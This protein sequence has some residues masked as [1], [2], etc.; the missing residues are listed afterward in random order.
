MRSSSSDDNRWYQPRPCSPTTASA[1]ARAAVE[2]YLAGATGPHAHQF[3]AADL[4]GRLV[5]WRQHQRKTAGTLSIRRGIGPAKH[6]DGIGVV[7]EAGEELLPLHRPLVVLHA[8]AGCQT[9][10]VGAA[11]RLGHAECHDEFTLHQTWQ[12]FGLLIRRTM[13]TK[14]ARR[15]RQQ[16]PVH[17]ERRKLP[18]QLLA[19]NSPGQGHRRH[20]R[21]RPP[22]PTNRSSPVRQSA[23]RSSAG[24]AVRGPSR[25]C[26]SPEARARRIAARCHEE[27][28]VLPVDRNSSVA[29]APVCC[30]KPVPQSSRA[31]AKTNST[32]CRTGDAVSCRRPAVSLRLSPS[33]GQYW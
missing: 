11:A 5:T 9:E 28:D 14:G 25:G 31:A 16:Q 18:R 27:A 17:G 12:V 3:Q 20:C 23:S 29:P 21:H 10:H 32:G 26:A 13:F 6:E 1:G 30:R 8:G 19:E 15:H 7:G 24:S 22:A 2:E 33:C 4:H